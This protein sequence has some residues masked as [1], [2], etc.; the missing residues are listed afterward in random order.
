MKKI[1]IVCITILIMGGCKPQKPL[2]PAQ[3]FESVKRA[4]YMNDSNDFYNL[5]SRRTKSKMMKASKTMQSLSVQQHRN[6]AKSLKISPSVL[7]NVTP[8]QYIQFY[9]AD[10]DNAVIKAI[11]DRRISIK[12]GSKNAVVEVSSGIELNFV[13][14]GPYWLLDLTD[15]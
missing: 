6:L 8:Q 9:L 12:K 15:H 7:K 13:K 4:V 5:L 2:T 10:R 11:K 3:A 1:L 14:E